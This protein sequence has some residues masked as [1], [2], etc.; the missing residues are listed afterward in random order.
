MNTKSIGQYIQFLRKQKNLSQ[1]RLAELLNISFQ[2]VSKWETGE[3]LPDASILLDLADILDTTTDR[4]L[5]GGSAIAKKQK[6]INIEDLK[7]G[8]YALEDMRVL[9][10]ENSLFYIGAVEGIYQRLR[11]NF[12]DCLRKESGKEI[13]LAEAVVHC[14]TNGY[15]IEQQD[16]DDNFKSIIIRRR[17]RKCLSDCGLFCGKS[18][19]YLDYRPSYPKEVKDLLLSIC[20]HPIIADIG[21]G[22]GKFSH[23]CIDQV[24]MLYAVEPNAQMR[25]AAEMLLGECTNYVSIAGTAEKTTLDDSSVDLITVAEA[26]HWFDN[27]ETKSEFRRI[28]K[29][30]GYVLL[31]W[32]Q[33]GGDPFDHEKLEI[34]AKYREIT[35]IKLSGIPREQRAINLFGEGNYKVF[36]FDNSIVQNCESFCSGWASASYIPKHG[37]DEYHNF[38]KQASDLF[39][40]YATNGL[41]KTTIK[42]ICFLGKL[43]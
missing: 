37:S 26:Y 6:K 32:N 20:K 21:S 22:T 10:G 15:Y 36:E 23:F 5:S 35:G 9:L 13:L 33:F 24:Q 18:K 11:I 31:L 12:D 7:Q 16:I 40:K 28:L 19:D 8:I 17:I 29:D 43:K 2:A 30:D 42:T 38:I 34:S 39:E 1:K 25:N 41:L 3:N 4:I 27:N 14:L